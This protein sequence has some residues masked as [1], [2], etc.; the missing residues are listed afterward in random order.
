M[1]DQYMGYTLPTEEIEVLKVLEQKMGSSWSNDCFKVVDNHITRIIVTRNTLTSL[2]E[3]IGNCKNLIHL[4][5]YSN[6]I[7]T[8]PNSV[9][10]LTNL[11]WLSAQQNKLYEL[12][13]NLANCTALKQLDLGV[14]ELTVLP[15]WISNL[16]NL[17]KLD[18]QID[19]PLF[20]GSMMRN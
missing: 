19:P 8:I 16:K 17:E 4:T 5:F 10:K 15:G 9:G 2:P 3:N 13:T 14:N 6:K 7:E 20:L 1:S 12:P 18:D 11:E